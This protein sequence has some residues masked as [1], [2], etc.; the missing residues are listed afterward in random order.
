[1]KKV[2]NIKKYYLA[3]YILLSE[4]SFFQI[5]NMNIKYIFY[6]NIISEILNFFRNNEKIIYDGLYKHL[7]ATCNF[8]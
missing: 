5:I 8:A 3:L 7:P 2:S 6:K 1:M 4:I